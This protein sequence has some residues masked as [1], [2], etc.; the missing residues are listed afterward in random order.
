[1]LSLVFTEGENI[2]KTKTDVCDYITFE[3]KLGEIFYF[4][5][6]PSNSNLNHLEEILIPNLN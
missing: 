1:M 3:E 2:N 6:I 4:S 5:Q